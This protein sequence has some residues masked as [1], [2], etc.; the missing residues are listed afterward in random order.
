MEIIMRYLLSL[1]VILSALAFASTASAAGTGKYCLRGP[2]GTLNCKYQTM[3]S[4]NKVKKSTQACVARASTTGAG[5]SR[6]SG[7][8]Y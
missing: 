5:M 2:G 4:C 6:S 3:A 8:K 1:V 7:K